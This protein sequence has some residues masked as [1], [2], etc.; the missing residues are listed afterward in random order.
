MSGLKCRSTEEG[1]FESMKV[2][3]IDFTSRPT[4]SKPLTC[5]NCEFDGSR[6][7]ATKIWVGINSYEGSPKMSSKEQNDLT[8]A[9]KRLWLENGAYG[10]DGILVIDVEGGDTVKVNSNSGKNRGW[11][12]PPISRNLSTDFSEHFPTGGKNDA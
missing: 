7:T 3:G 2:I 4:K 8:H 6:T 11:L 1:D 12:L 10:R 5:L 9:L